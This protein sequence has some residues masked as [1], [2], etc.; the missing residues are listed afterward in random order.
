MT[1]AI[2]KLEHMRSEGKRFGKAGWKFGLGS[3]GQ[4]EEKE[5]LLAF[6]TS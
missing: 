2:L 5:P 1:P 6:P 4:V 3:W